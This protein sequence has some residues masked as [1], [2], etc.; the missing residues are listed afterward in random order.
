VG[1][2]TVGSD[3]I[4]RKGPEGQDNNWNDDWEQGKGPDSGRNSLG[5]SI[6]GSNRSWHGT[7]DNDGR[8]PL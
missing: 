6:D 1:G 4:W 7:I 8:D 5:A 3:L 2:M